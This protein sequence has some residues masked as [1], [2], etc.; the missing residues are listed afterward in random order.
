MEWLKDLPK[1][2]V[3]LALVLATLFLV[4]YAI[5]V[6]APIFKRK[7]ED[8][9]SSCSYHLANTDKILGHDVW[10]G[11]IDK[12]TSML[13]KSV[14]SLEEHTKATDSRLDKLEQAVVSLTQAVL[15]MSEKV[16]HIDKSLDD[17]KDHLNKK[18]DLIFE[19]K[20]R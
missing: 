7:K 14:S 17:F 2:Y 13:E 19:K 16:N 18:L 9:K 20:R 4:I 12:R 1:E 8:E 6:L 11:E 3:P 15:P 5:S 10:L